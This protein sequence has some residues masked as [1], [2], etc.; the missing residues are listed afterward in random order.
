VYFLLQLFGFYSQKTRWYK[1]SETLDPQVRGKGNMTTVAGIKGPW[2]L[3][4]A[5]RLFRF[6]ELM[7]LFRQRRGLRAFILLFFL[8]PYNY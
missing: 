3:H 6:S 7:G 4:T 1:L 5:R 8:P 2:I